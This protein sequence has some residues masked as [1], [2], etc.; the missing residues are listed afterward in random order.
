MRHLLL[1][2]IVCLAGCATMRDANMGLPGGDSN[3]APQGERTPPAAPGNTAQTGQGASVATSVTVPAVVPV[4]LV[5][6]ICYIAG[7]GMA[8]AAVAMCLDK[9]SDYWGHRRELVKLRNGHGKGNS[10]G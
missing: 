5:I 3:S 1:L 7:A 2:T 6:A 4:S 9:I 10:C 8:L